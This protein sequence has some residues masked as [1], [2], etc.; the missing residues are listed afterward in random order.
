MSTGTT[1][2]PV[3]AYDVTQKNVV[4][5][6]DKFDGAIDMI[7]IDVAGQDVNGAFQ[8]EIHPDNATLLLK[9]WPGIPRT[10][11]ANGVPDNSLPSY[12]VDVYRNGLDKYFRQTGVMVDTLRI[13]CAGPDGELIGNFD[14]HGKQE[15]EISS[16]S[17][18][19]LPDQASFQFKHTHDGT[20][21]TVKFGAT[22]EP[23]ITQFE[24]AVPNNLHPSERRDTNG[25]RIW[26]DA[27]VRG[28]IT[29]SGN[30]RSHTDWAL[31]YTGLVRGQNTGTAFEVTFNYP[32]TGSPIDSVK[33]ELPRLVLAECNPAGGARDIESHTLN[34]T[35]RKTAGQDAIV[36]TNT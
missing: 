1:G 24:I 10:G 20:V 34:G 5:A 2:V 23:N 36:I 22:A 21:S 4:V 28:E 6:R 32:G 13:S 19:T 3:E 26:I 11:Q 27:G 15:T 18:P 14:C 12:T 31:D 16:F 35:A 8:A 7:Q 33:I 17:R 25:R 30:L 9:T 29:F